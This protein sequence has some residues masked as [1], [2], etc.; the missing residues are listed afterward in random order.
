MS[1]LALR[2]VAGLAVAAALVVPAAAADRPPDEI[3]GG[4]DAP[5]GE[6]PFMV[7]LVANGAPT[8]FDGQFCGGSLMNRRW[9]L[10]AAHCVDGV[11]PDAF[12]VI[13]GR[14][15][16]NNDGGEKRG[17]AEIVVH[18]E[19]TVTNQSVYNDVAVLRL[20][21]QSTRQR[22]GL[23][24]FAQLELWEDG[25]TVRA[26]GWGE[27]EDQTFPEHLQQADIRVV[28]DSQCA[29]LWFGIE[30]TLHTCAGGT[31]RSVCVGDSGGPLLVA[32]GSSWRQVAVVSYGAQPCRS[33]VP[34]VYSQVGTNPLR[35][36]IVDQTT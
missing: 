29:D 20:K 36:W 30:G 3:Y 16:L 4:V 14:T 35:A 21:S 24:S 5:L 17:I 8:P 6:Y 18:P 31:V 32:L 23:A 33:G 2:A 10:T 26:I 25:D 27:L 19:Y 34:D 22:I 1:R 12:H 11:D 9:V 7:A 13:I 15:R 28:G